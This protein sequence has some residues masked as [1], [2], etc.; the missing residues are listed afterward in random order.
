MTIKT[1]YLAHNFEIRKKIR[2]WE[3][4]MEGKYNIN[5]DNPFYDHDRNDIRALDNLEDGSP[6]QDRYFKERNTD[7]MVELIVE[8]DLELIRKSDGIVTQ[9][10][11]PSIGTSMEII[12]AARI[13]GIPV[14]VITKKYAFHPW[15]KKH[16]TMTFSNTFEFE[17]FLEKNWGRKK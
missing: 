12:M 14:Y 8:G 3:L 1:L 10:K 15:I 13:Y 4:R 11:S 5:L 9:I 6:E 7:A 16:A 17:K 2:K